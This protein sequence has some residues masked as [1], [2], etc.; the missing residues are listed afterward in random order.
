VAE[1][2]PVIT[3]GKIFEYLGAKIPIL[4]IV[5]PE[6]EAGRLIQSLGVGKVISPGNISEIEDALL[7]FYREFESGKPYLKTYPEQA[8]RYEKKYLTAKLARLLDELVKR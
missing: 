7:T 3:T 8:K 4:A 5:P 1:P 2:A 6:G